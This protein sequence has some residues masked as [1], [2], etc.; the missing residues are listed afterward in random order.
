MS[1]FIRLVRAKKEHDFDLAWQ[2]L[3]DEIWVKKLK[4]APVKLNEGINVCFAPKRFCD[5]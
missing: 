3:Q 1:L 2:L 5:T 4:A